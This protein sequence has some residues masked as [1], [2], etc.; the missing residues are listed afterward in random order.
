MNPRVNFA[1]TLGLALALPVVLM[2]ACKSG[3]S[4]APQSPR[5]SAAPTAREQGPCD[6]YAAGG[7]PCVAAH[8]TTRALFVSY[9]RRLYQV[10]RQ[11]DGK[12]LDIG[13]DPGGYANAAA[14]DEFCA[15]DL[16]F[17]S[18]IYDQSGK[19][20][21]LYQAPPGTFK[22][23]A[24][25]AF[26]TLP[27]ADMAPITVHGRKAYGV[28][29]MPGMGFRNNNAIGLA[30]NDEPEGVYYVIDGAHYDSGCCFD[31]GNASPN[32][33]AV[34]TGTMETVYFGTAT[35]WGSGAGPGPWI[36]ADFEAGLFTGYSAKQNPGSPTITSWRFLTAVV[37]G[38]GGNHWDLRGGNAQQGPLTTFYSGVRPVSSN[39]TAYFPMHKQGAVLLGNGGD[40]GN[41]SSGTFYEGVMTTG[42]PTEA[43]TDAVQANIV[44]AKYDVQRVSLSRVATFTPGASQDTLV[45]FKNTTGA[46]V[47]DVKLSLAAPTGW[48]TAAAQTFPGPVAPGASVSA[49]F[50]IASPAKNSAGFL[51]AK[52]EWKSAAGT[53][54]DT[55]SQRA[56][57]APPV[58][59]N[60]VRF[61]GQ[62]I[63]L[64]NASAADAD[65]SGW[66]ITNTQSQ[67]AP[68][69]LAAIPANTKIP[70]HGFYLL[71][72]ASSGLVAPAQ[73]GDASIL[74]SDVS[75]FQPGQTIDIDGETRAISG[76]GV[77]AT[78]MTTLF[79]PVSTGPW[80]TIPA[81]STNLPVTSASGFETGQKIGIDLG[82]NYEVATVTAVGKAST[83]TTLSSETATGANRLKLADVSNLTNGDTLTVGT[84]ARKE[85]AIVKTVTQA[86][87]ATNGAGFGRRGGMGG[88]PGEVELAAPL[89]IN[90]MAGIDVSSP[91]TGINFTPATRFAHRSGDAVQALGSGITLDKP[92][93]NAHEPGAPVVNAA[94]ASGYQGPPAP[95]QWFGGALSP[96][97][98]SVALYDASGKVLV[99]A[100]IYGAQQSS[101]S[102]NGTIASPE[103]AVL[104]GDQGKGGCIVVVPNASRSGGRGRGAADGLPQARRRRPS[105]SYQ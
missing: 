94:V 78:P 10:T 72:L 62:F 6:I 7:T 3:L 54:S 82:G 100:M 70:A 102:A 95:N 42:F 33:R 28:Y 59:I 38:G 12:T 32:S 73:K 97:A 76:V 4:P 55:T 37:D 36:M 58:K 99:D 53:A 93:N 51:T 71:G 25:G 66:V 83:Q 105:V 91:G 64:Y 30:I 5:P 9:N 41:G 85:F 101:S 20:N 79:I 21:H 31:Y 63:E 14:Q 61:G 13:V 87:P 77:A 47:T 45:T 67:W 84:G 80:L 35:A 57:S 26:N 81:G 69:K 50:A 89:T 90:H 15:G 56:R 18:V 27:I 2:V 17:I 48:K 74:V 98:G 75:G 104:E 43:T 65:I 34:G 60:E 11:S 19:G 49:P 44:A 103:L 88:A 8:S 86:S 1:A 40:N 16:C 22:G 96:S 68:V 52:A 23:P 46:E 92:L 29:I 24:K 39:N